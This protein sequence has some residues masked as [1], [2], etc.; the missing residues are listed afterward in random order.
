MTDEQIKEKLTIVSDRIGHFLNGKCTGFF[1]GGCFASLVRGEDPKDYDIWFR[2][3]EDYQAVR[4]SI[5]DQ[6]VKE[7]RFAVTIL[8]PTG[9]EVQFVRNRIG[10][11][12]ITSSSFDFEHTRSYFDPNTQEFRL[13]HHH[14]ENKI[15][16]YSRGKLCHPVNSFQRV[17]KFAREGY[18]MEFE[19]IQAMM[20]D[21]KEVPEDM[22]TFNHAGS[23]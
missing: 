2:S 6:F 18:R 15:L 1:A 3:K 4:D 9:E 8:L 11:P 19:S 17:M 12:E 20:M 14:I 5:G 22:I 21:F 13:A 10:T 7:S 16:T 23:R